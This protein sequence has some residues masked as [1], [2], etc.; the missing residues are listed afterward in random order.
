V[1]KPGARLWS[2]KS[3]KKRVRCQISRANVSTKRIAKKIRFNQQ[4]ATPMTVISSR[5]LAIETIPVAMTMA[6]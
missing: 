2:I 4:S 5:S 6:K 3:Q 1:K